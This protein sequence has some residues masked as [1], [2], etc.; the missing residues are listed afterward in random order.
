MSKEQDKLPVAYLEV[1]GYGWTCPNCDEWANVDV[2]DPILLQNE[3][4]ILCL[5]CKC[6]TKLKMGKP[7]D[8][9]RRL[10]E[11]VQMAYWQGHEHCGGD[12]DVVRCKDG[13]VCPD[14]AYCKLSGELGKELEG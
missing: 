9:L 10:F 12:F 7:D 4:I 11:L 2:D 5:C 3:V 13:L 1:G 8:K 14:Y 6:K